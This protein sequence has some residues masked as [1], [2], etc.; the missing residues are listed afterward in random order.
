MCG[1]S[2]RVSLTKEGAWLDWDLAVSLL[3]HS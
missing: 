3:G 2:L 1:K